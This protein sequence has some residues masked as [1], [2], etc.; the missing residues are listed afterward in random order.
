MV[1]RQNDTKIKANV[2]GSVGAEEMEEIEARSSLDSL[3]A[4]FNTRISELQ[5]L[6]IA[7]N[8]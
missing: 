3:M 4:S 1:S 8:S 2:H 6:V 7:R 5:Q